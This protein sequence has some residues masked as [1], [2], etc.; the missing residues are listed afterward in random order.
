M[1]IIT[2]LHVAPTEF[3]MGRI[4]D[5]AVRFEHTVPVG[6][7]VFPYAWVTTDDQLAFCQRVQTSTAVNS[8]TQ[9]SHDEDTASSKDDDTTTTALYNVEWHAETDGF[10]SCLTTTEVAVLDATG[11]NSGWSFRLRFDDH[12][13]LSAFQDV[14]HSHDIT[15]SV[16]RIVTDAALDGPSTP[17]TALQRETVERALARGYFDVPRKLTMVELAEELGISDQA[18]SARMRRATKNLLEYVLDTEGE[19]E[20]AAQ[21]SG[22]PQM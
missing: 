5:T 13:Q 21:T 18:V 3:E 4:G 12:D 16:N 1:T 6:E 17:L 20:T 8:V 14:C 19:T 10:L 22:P 9:L 7:D 2:D 15:P 11:S